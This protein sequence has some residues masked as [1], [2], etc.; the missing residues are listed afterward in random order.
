MRIEL[1]E[2]LH[3]LKDRDW[4]VNPTYK[5]DENE[6]KKLIN[7]LELEEKEQTTYD[8]E[9][10]YDKFRCSECG[11]EVNNWSANIEDYKFQYCPDCGRKIIEVKNV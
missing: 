3:N 6:A 9:D 4:D 2:L 10:E 11:I 5:I 7:A 1:K 8:T